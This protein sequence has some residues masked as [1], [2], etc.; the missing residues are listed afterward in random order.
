MKVGVPICKR[1][2]FDVDEDVHVGIG[3][4]PLAGEDVPDVVDEVIE[5]H[6]EHADAANKVQLPNAP[7]RAAQ[8]VSAPERGGYF[9]AKARLGAARI[10]GGGEF[11][12]LALG[13]GKL[14]RELFRRRGGGL[15]GNIVAAQSFLRAL[16]RVFALTHSAFYYITRKKI[17]QIIAAGKAEQ[18]EEQTFENFRRALA[19]Y[20]NIC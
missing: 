15:L 5:D 8:L 4:Y 2:I 20:A 16:F 1:H 3:G 7:R 14:R 9:F 11:A 18:K 10:C 6:E 12:L 17:R 19:F 13:R